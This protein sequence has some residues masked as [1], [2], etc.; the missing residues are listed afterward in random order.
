MRLDE[1]YNRRSS[2]VFGLLSIFLLLGIAEAANGSVVYTYDS[3]AGSRRLATILA[4][5]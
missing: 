1:S 3:W 4:S 2:L 5:L